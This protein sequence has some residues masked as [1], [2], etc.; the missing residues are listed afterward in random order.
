MFAA[1]ISASQRKQKKVLR[2]PK[3]FNDEIGRFSL[4]IWTRLMLNWGNLKQP[5]V[6]FQKYS[7]GANKKCF[8]NSVPIE[9][10]ETLSFTDKNLHRMHRNKLINFDIINR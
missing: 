8:K 7:E 10:M 1:E 2:F 3:S 9:T 5:S 4:D 6:R